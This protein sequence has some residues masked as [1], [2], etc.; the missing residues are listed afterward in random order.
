LHEQERALGIVAGAL[1]AA[2]PLVSSAADSLPAPLGGSSVL[3][4]EGVVKGI[5]QAKHAVTVV[6][7]HGGEASFTVTDASNLAQLHQGSKVH[8]RMVRS[9][10]VSPTHGAAGVQSL[11]Q[12][13]TAEIVTLDLARPAWSS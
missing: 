9:A 4:A 5:D 13:V 8:V 11:P 3:Q 7:V 12:N 1:I 2:A 6:D 10:L